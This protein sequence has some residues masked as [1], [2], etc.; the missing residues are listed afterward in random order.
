MVGG[1]L[2]HGNIVSA[3]SAPTP[4]TPCH[5]QHVL[6]LHGIQLSHHSVAGGTPRWAREP[7]NMGH[8]VLAK[9]QSLNQASGL[10]HCIIGVY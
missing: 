4:H 10:N 3:K 2:F 6:Y 1:M 8:A 9:P 7:L 5:G